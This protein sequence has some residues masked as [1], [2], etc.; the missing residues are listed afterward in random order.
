VSHLRT[1][2]K[3]TFVYGIGDV[4]LFGISYLVMIPMLTR[5]LSPEEYGVV[6]T[7]NT[8]S[9][10]LVAVLQLGLPS[11]AFRFWYLQPTRERQRS[12][13]AS[14]WLV[15]IAF[16]AV[17]AVALLTFA[18]PIWDQFIAR[19]AF[20]E[21]AP[22]IV[23]GAFFQVVIAF[24]SILLRALDRPRLYIT[25]D[26]CQFVTML[27]LV[28]YQVIVL[29]RG[30]M[31]QVQGV[32]L[33]LM[34]F[35]IIS[36]I[37][38]MTQCRLHFNREGILR[39]FQFAW[40][41]VVGGLVSLIATRSTILITQCYVAGAAV[42][43]FALG[44]QIGSLVQ[45][46]AASL[47]KA[48]QP[49][50]YGRDPG[51]ARHSLRGLLDLSAPIYTLVAMVL[52]LFAPEVIGLLASRD[53]SSAWIIA[54]IA[55][56][57]ALCV[58]LSSIVNG[59]LYYATRSGLSLVVTAIAAAAN[60]LLCWVL[61]PRFGIVGAA[62]ATA[63]AGAVSLTFML[64]AVRGVFDS[65]INHKRVFGVVLFGLGLSTIATAVSFKFMQQIPVAV[66]GVKCAAIAVY[67]I[68]I[69]KLGWYHAI[70]WTVRSS[71]PGDLSVETTRIVETE[72]T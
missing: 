38:V 1:L 10:F 55:A 44:S 59:G 21:Y 32:F 65:G 11:A 26:I 33:T 36:T 68:V 22:Y 50:L 61:I 29:H 37:I 23:W 51:E 58:A 35:A 5:Y 27:A 14:I 47:E 9:V 49:Y 17:L 70:Q 31:G 72:R 43:L 25:V 67:I 64:V 46:A 15:A 2:I 69:W 19:A 34:I 45:L 60:L 71:T 18:R 6:A 53:Y 30:V 57:G 28:A 20:N 24:K 62:M 52:A 48:W 16:T 39:T 4:L 54:D 7:L 63:V 8:L 42:G 3:S 40:P 41:V 66:W 12:Y 13:L 56:F